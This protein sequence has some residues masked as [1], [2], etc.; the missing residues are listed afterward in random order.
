MAVENHGALPGGGQQRRRHRRLL[1]WWLAA[2]ALVKRGLH[3]LLVQGTVGQWR[4]NGYDTTSAKRKYSQL[5]CLRCVVEKW[6]FVHV[7]FAVN[8]WADF[9]FVKDWADFFSS[10]IW[11]I[12]TELR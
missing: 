9:F 10:W 1:S 12:F 4:S 6:A 11:Q 8:D 5:I 3:G 2:S 7:E